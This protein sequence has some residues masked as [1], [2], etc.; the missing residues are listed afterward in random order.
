MKYIPEWVPGA[1]FKKTARQWREVIFESYNKPFYFVK[2]QMVSMAGLYVW[3]SK[4]L[5]PDDRVTGLRY[6]PSPLKYWEKV[7][8]IRKKRI[9]SS[10]QLQRY[11]AEAQIRFAYH[12]MHHSIDLTALTQ[13][14]DCQRVLNLLPGHGVKSRYIEAS[15]RRG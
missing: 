6:L 14:S 3:T 15:S 8:L 12:P 1:T 2:K 13:R 7:L 11:T 10:S 9:S 5:I 4:K